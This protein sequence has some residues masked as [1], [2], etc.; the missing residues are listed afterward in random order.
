MLARGC[1]RIL[2]PTTKTCIPRWCCNFSASS[3][4]LADFL[5]SYPSSLSA[6]A[7]WSACSRK[8]LTH[9]CR[10]SASCHRP[11]AIWTFQGLHRKTGPS[12]QLPLEEDPPPQSSVV[13]SRLPGSCPGCQMQAH[14]RV[15]TS[16]RRLHVRQTCCAANCCF[17]LILGGMDL[18][19]TQRCRAPGWAVIPPMGWGRNQSCMGVHSDPG[20]SHQRAGSGVLNSDVDVT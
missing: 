3:T 2:I 17:V 12:S 13:N 6:S 19:E 16:S 1:R 18:L 5:S 14:P 11:F 20:A 8:G 10:I 7:S 9:P 15:M 4:P